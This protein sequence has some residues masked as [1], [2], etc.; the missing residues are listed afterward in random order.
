MDSNSR[1]QKSFE[2]ASEVS[3]QLI[4]LSTAAIAITIAFK[5]DLVG[6]SS[7]PYLS[8]LVI[9]WVFF[10]LSTLG[11]ILTLMAL[12]GELV[13]G[14][15]AET[16]GSH[17]PHE[18]RIPTI[19]RGNIRFLCGLQTSCFLIAIIL[20]IFFAFLGVKQAGASTNKEPVATSS[21]PPPSAPWPWQPPCWS[22]G[23]GGAPTV[24]GRWGSWWLP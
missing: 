19:Y 24:E 5:K 23:A 20:T 10:L 16:S 13:G 17:A 2:F 22:G 18:S 6:G 1:I 8:L 9:I 7:G 15:P 12:A 4:T 14:A 21:G 3:K 11:G